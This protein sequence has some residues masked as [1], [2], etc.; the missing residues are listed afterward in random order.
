MSK[1]LFLLSG[2]GSTD[3][4]TTET[5]EII[6]DTFHEGPLTHL[7]RQILPVNESSECVFRFVSRKVLEHV[8]KTAR[9][10]KKI[11]RR[12]KDGEKGNV[13]F[14][15]NAAYLGIVA[16]QKQKDENVPVVAIFFKDSDGTRAKSG[17][18]QGKYDSVI[19]GFD[20]ANFTRGVP[21]L[22]KPISE[23]WFLCAIYRKREPHPE[24]KFHSLEDTT[25]GD[26]NESKHQLKGELEKVLK[27]KPTRELLND[28]IQNGEIDFQHINLPS[29]N[30]FKQRLEKVIST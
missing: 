14:F 10:S 20:A 3:I 6:G 17:D 15:F 4:G 13:Y 1:L 22:A 16:L 21:M 5:P 25:F 30:Q 23:A 27:E 9:E 8:G 12:S 28:K 19:A 11:R 18:W 24:E 29:F 2:E 26:V 7:I